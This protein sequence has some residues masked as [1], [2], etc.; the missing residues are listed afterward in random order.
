MSNLKKDIEEYISSMELK[1]NKIEEDLDKKGGLDRNV[2]MGMGMRS[3]V[4]LEVISDLK[5]IA[6]K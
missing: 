3:Q 2:R 4:Y 5:N 1:R 6:I